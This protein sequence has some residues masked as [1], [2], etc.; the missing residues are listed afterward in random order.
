MRYIFRLLSTDFSSFS[1]T[2][3]TK[4]TD[5]RI[6]NLLPV[7]LFFK[8]ILIKILPANYSHTNNLSQNFL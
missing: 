3:P 7:F 2:F 6:K 8:A 5:K 4:K 1:A